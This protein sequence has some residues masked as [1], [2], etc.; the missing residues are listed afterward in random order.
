MRN[1][2]FLIHLADFEKFPNGVGRVSEDEIEVKRGG[3]ACSVSRI[4][5]DVAGAESSDE[6]EEG[7]PGELVDALGDELKLH[8]VL[9]AD[10]EVR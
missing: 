5:R 10:C 3:R 7:R 1:V 9:G 8:D 2:D 4:G 6:S